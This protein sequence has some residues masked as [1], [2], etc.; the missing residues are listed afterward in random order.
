MLNLKKL[1][2]NLFGT[3]GYS[4]KSQRAR[5]RVEAFEER[6]CPAGTWE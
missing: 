4:K 3:G 6:W 2:G 1:L 5:L